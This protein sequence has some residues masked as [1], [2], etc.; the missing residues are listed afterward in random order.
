[1]A[2]VPLR[3][4]RSAPRGEAEVLRLHVPQ[5]PW[6]VLAKSGRYTSAGDRRSGGIRKVQSGGKP[7]GTSARLF[8][9]DERRQVERLDDCHS[10]DSP[11]P[12]HRRARGC[13]APLPNS[14]TLAP[15]VHRD[16]PD[17]SR[18]VVT[19]RG[20]APTP[21]YRAAGRHA[22]RSAPVAP[23]GSGRSRRG[24]P[25]RQTPPEARTQAQRPVLAVAW[26]PE[27]TPH[28]LWKLWVTRVYKRQ[29]VR[30]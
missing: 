13:R 4:R 16:R 2:P 8:P 14:P 25:Q 22:P 23:R 24:G 10:A 18:S 28:Y 1:V 27:I 21:Y 12:S 6:I 17:Y 30:A 9:R 11:A 20:P 15:L 19:R 29:A 3:L 26:G 7:G 5:W